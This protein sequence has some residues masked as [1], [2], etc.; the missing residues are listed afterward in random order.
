MT[1]Q[2]WF[3]Q[4]W[5][6]YKLLLTRNNSKIHFNPCPHS[7]QIICISTLN[8]AK[9]M[10]NFFRLHS[11]YVGIKENSLWQTFKL[12]SFFKIEAISL[13]VNSC[14]SFFGI[15]SWCDALHLFSFKKL[16]S[17]FPNM[18]DQCAFLH[19]FLTRWIWHLTVLHLS[20]YISVKSKNIWKAF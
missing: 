5:H 4:Y 16:H 8:S 12:A 11:Y 17:V 9:Q 6:K 1:S 3:I 13:S 20:C 18:L 19:V 10:P 2:T 15:L 14:Y 7:F